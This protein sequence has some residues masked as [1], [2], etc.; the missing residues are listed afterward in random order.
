MSGIFV[1]IYFL[2][3][4]ILSYAMQLVSTLVVRALSFQSMFNTL[5]ICNLEV[6]S[7]IE[8]TRLHGKSDII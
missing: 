7:V 2:I 6:Q 5:L 3:A 8:I 1:D 4:S